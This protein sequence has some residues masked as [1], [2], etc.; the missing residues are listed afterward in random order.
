MKPILLFAVISFLISACGPTSE[1]PA[2]TASAA[3][4]QT[5]TAAPTETPP[6][7][8]TATYMPSPTTPPTFTPPP[9]LRLEDF[10]VDVEL[11]CDPGGIS[12]YGPLEYSMDAGTI[13]SRDFFARADDFKEAQVAFTAV[14]V[15]AVFFQSNS[16]LLVLVPAQ[17]ESNSRQPGIVLLRGDFGIGVKQYPPHSKIQVTGLFD[18]LITLQEKRFS[19]TTHE[20]YAFFVAEIVSGGCAMP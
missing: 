20:E 4:A 6:P 19:W 12:F 11:S 15:E 14:V 1:E 18:Q 5:Q 9:E 10:Q 16:F 7:T 2:A 13:E 8:F 3:R 17:A